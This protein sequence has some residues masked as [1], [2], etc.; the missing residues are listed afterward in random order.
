VTWKKMA[1]FS[2]FFDRRD[3]HTCMNLL[4]SFWVYTATD[5]CGREPPSP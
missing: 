5:Q 1:W 2:I 4:A 3:S